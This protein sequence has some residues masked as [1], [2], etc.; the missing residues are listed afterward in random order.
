[1]VAFGTG[2]DGAEVRVADAVAD[3][4]V[5]DVGGQTMEA[6]GEVEHLFGWLFE[7]MECKTQCGAFADAGQRR[8]GIDGLG[9]G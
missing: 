2:T 3:T 8:E 4:A 1:L 6:F 7:Q 9:E 5:V